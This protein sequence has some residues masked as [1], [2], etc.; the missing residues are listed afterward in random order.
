MQRA[1]GWMKD[2]MA[3]LQLPNMAAQQHE[4]TK[5]IATTVL[6]DFNQVNEAAYA[7]IVRKKRVRF[8]A[9]TLFNYWDVPVADSAYR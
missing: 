4:I 7:T 3:C 2:R 9:R 1:Q 5:W 8:K 6:V